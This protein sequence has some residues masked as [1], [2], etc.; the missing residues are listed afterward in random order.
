MLAGFHAHKDIRPNVGPAYCIP[1]QKNIVAMFCTWLL[2]V[3]FVW[4]S[5]LTVCDWWANSLLEPLVS[6]QGFFLRGW[7]RNMSHPHFLLW[8]LEC[9]LIAGRVFPCYKKGIIVKIIRDYNYYILHKCHFLCQIMLFVINGWHDL[10]KEDAFH[11]FP[12]SFSPSKPT[13]FRNIVMHIQKKR[14]WWGLALAIFFWR[15]L[16]CTTKTRLS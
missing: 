5:C 11:I 9:W 14:Q 10:T 8:Y 15:Q 4:K 1:G 3:M 6:N 2:R 13:V 7:W 12:V 16:L